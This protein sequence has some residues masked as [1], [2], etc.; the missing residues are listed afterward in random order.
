MTLVSTGNSKKPY[1]FRTSTFECCGEIF[2]RDNLDPKQ[3][4]RIREQLESGEGCA[5]PQNMAAKF[6]AAGIE[7]VID[8]ASTT[9]AADLLEEYAGLLR[10][11]VDRAKLKSR[12]ATF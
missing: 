3:E 11:Q 8:G 2:E 9:Q 4:D 10:S 7:L 12:V 5:M 1:T 6:E